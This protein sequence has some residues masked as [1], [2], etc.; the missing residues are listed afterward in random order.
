MTDD[1]QLLDSGGNVFNAA[2]DY[3]GTTYYQRIKLS[4]G[5]DGAAVDTSATNP[6]PIKVGTVV[7][8][9]G[10][11]TRP[12]DTNTYAA[13]DVINEATSGSTVITFTGCARVTGGSGLIQKVMIDDSANQTL[14]LQCE[15]WLFNAS[16]AST[17]H[18]NAVFTPADA[19]RPV[20]IIP[21]SNSYVGDA[22][23]GA[24]GN[25]VLTSGVINN[26]FVCAADANLY[27]VLVARNAYV[28][29]AQEVFNIRLLIAQD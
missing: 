19:G 26:P 10:S 2:A 9:S 21:I 20:A 22:Q 15:L 28:P 8:I 16:P 25:A 27:G 23:S 6:L 12:N 11:K 17:G 4:W 24:S 13:G 14:K 29:I 1:V 3:I 18:D 5:V 7:E